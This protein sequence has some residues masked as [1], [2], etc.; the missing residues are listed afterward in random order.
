MKVKI[1]PYIRWIGPYQLSDMIPFISEERKEKIGAYLSETWVNSVCA[2]FYD[3]NQRKI[4]VR[5]DPYDTWNMDHTLAL[6]ILPMLKQLKETSRGSPNVDDEDLPPHMRHSDPKFSED[7]W[8]MGD[9]WVHYKWEWVLNEIIW[10][11]EEWAKDERE[12]RF[13]YNNSFDS[14]GF[15]EYNERIKNGFRLFGKYYT[16]LWD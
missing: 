12:E 10:S 2:W 11:F 16:G 9:N 1:G 5:I 7:G 6:I 14:E 4:E 3:M 13:F 8:D 15:I